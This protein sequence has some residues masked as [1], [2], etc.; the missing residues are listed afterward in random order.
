MLSKAGFS[1]GEDKTGCKAE[2]ANIPMAI[3]RVV[4]IEAVAMAIVE[5][6]SPYS[7]FAF[8]PALSMAFRAAGTFKAVTLPVTK[9][10]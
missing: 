1:T 2:K 8:T 7:V 5:M 3:T 9:L 10:R 4:T 6:I